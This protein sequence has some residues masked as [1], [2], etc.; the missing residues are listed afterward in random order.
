[1]NSAKMLSTCLICAVG[2]TTISGCTTTGAGEGYVKKDGLEPPVA[3]SWKSEDGGLDGTMTAVM[4]DGELYKG[5]FYEITSRTVI[6]VSDPFWDGW[7]PGWD[8]WTW[9]GYSD[10][11]WG[12]YPVQDFVT[13]YSGKVVANLKD[14][15][16]GMRMRCRFTLE[17]PDAGMS[18]GGSGECQTSDKKVVEAKFPAK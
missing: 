3:L 12:D 9:D 4:P 14:P 17:Q 6:N 11:T 7:A 1:M 13:N 18:G 8:D 10:W 15:N 5:K 16:N 2:V